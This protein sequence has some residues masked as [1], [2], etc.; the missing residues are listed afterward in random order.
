MPGNAKSLL[1]GA[2]DKTSAGLAPGDD[3]YRGQLSAIADD[4]RH[5]SGMEAAPPARDG[6]PDGTPLWAGLPWERFR[7]GIEILR[8]QCDGGEDSAAALLRYRAGTSG[9]DHLHTGDEHILVLEGSQQDG[10]GRY[11]RGATVLN[12]AG[13]SHRVSSPEGCVVGIFWE[14]PVRFA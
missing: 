7:D 14:K 5:I 13:S 6:T 10:R 11:S 8:L 4:I 1:L 9:P 12:P 3:W 2:L